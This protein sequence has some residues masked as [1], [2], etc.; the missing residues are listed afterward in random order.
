MSDFIRLRAI[1]IF[2][3]I[4]KMQ[5]ERT[6]NLRFVIEFKGQDY[7]IFEFIDLYFK[8]KGINGTHS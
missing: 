4:N 3:R 8:R 5:G 2:F 1:A 6:K 7:N